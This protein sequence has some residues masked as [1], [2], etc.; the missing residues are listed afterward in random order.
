MPYFL[1]ITSIVLTLAGFL[2]QYGLWFDLTAHFRLQYFVFQILCVILCLF[3][4]RKKLL[5]LAT[6]FAFINFSLIAPY[7]FPSTQSKNQ[8]YGSPLKILSI[9]LNSQN[10][11]YAAVSK[12]I[13]KT[14][15]DILGLEEL[16]ERWVTELQP[17]LLNYPYHKE[18]PRTDGFGI[19]V[20]SKIPFENF[21]VKNFAEVG[22]P[23]VV[24]KF[25]WEKHPVSI[26][27]THPVPP[28][29]SKYYHWR[30]EQ[31]KNIATL[32]PSLG[33][34]VIMVGDLNTTSWSYHFQKLIKETGLKDSR[35][36]LGLQTSWPFLP[37]IGITLDHC[38]LSEN[39]VVLERKVGPNVG[40][41]HLPLFIKVALR[42][43][44]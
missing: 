41:D 23:S 17:V 24:G 3:Q 19:G 9:N 16:T 34:N 8:D 42:L 39:F 13:N 5:Y 32:K 37:Y 1:L 6:I 4:N 22:I 26:I 15:P 36:G 2:S 10:T 27:F 44:H 14:S 21:E 40:S 20:Y 29:D 18:V 30:N 25:F 43:S 12:H 28:I 11:N 31:F 35:M 7:Y 38:L 33:K